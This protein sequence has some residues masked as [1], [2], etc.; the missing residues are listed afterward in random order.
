VLR[1]WNNEVLGNIDGVW[2]VIAAEINGPAACGG[3]PIPTFPHKREGAYG[4][5]VTIS[6]SY[7]ISSADRNTR[8]PAA[9]NR[10]IS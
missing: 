2:Q 9:A 1:F 8:F 7:A 10:A 3:T 5:A 4:E 6:D